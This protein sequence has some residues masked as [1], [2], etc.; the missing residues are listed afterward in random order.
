MRKLFEAALFIYFITIL[1]LFAALPRYD[2]YMRPPLD[3]IRVT[4]DYGYRWGRL[5]R[6]TDLAAETGDNVY[7]V[8]DGRVV[9]AGEYGS[10]GKMA[11]VACSESITVYY[12][13]L[14]S[15]NVTKGERI[16]RGQIIGEAGS[17]GNAT[18]PHLHFEVRYKGESRN[19]AQFI[20]KIGA[21]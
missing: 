12:A 20:D 9:K 19:P 15:I 10:C 18:G 2:I 1:L 8:C 14:D 7:S 21:M 11:A 5:H 6:G 4:S 16:D 17:S 13:H 3:S